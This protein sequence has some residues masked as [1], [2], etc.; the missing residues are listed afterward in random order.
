MVT[1]LSAFDKD[2]V[3]LDDIARAVVIGEQAIRECYAEALK[4]QTQLLP[5]YLQTGGGHFV[6]ITNLKQD[7]EYSV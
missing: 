3:D 4:Y 1:S 7:P 2:R 5:K 6:S